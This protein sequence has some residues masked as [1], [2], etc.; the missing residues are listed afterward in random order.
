MGTV[1]D[2]ASR[3]R[4]SQDKFPSRLL[5]SA[6]ESAAESTRNLA[7]G[8]VIR[9]SEG[10]TPAPTRGESPPPTSLRKRKHRDHEEER[11]EEV[12]HA[13]E[14]PEQRS[15]I[16]L[17]SQVSVGSELP[18]EV[19]FTITLHGAPPSPETADDVDPAGRN[20]SAST[21]AGD[22][23]YGSLLKRHKPVRCLFW[24]ACTKGE[25]CEFHHPTEN[26]KYVFILQSP[27]QQ[28][29]YAF[30]QQEFPQL[31]AWQRLSVYSPNTSVQV[32]QRLCSAE[33]CFYPPATP[34][35][36]NPSSSCA[37]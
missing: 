32:R 33:L 30:Y 24:P 7:E 8:Q 16:T 11:I 5:F 1:T 31:L 36:Y 21:E 29:S 35:S 26:C 3:L 20:A 34:L 19:S 23:S 22:I 28:F 14:Q 2:R 37:T 10:A 9:R 27:N 13:L 6:V 17:H 18:S 15:E 12:T 25:S 4:K